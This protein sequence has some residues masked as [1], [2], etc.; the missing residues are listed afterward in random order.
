MH[1]RIQTSPQAEPIEIEHIKVDAFRY[2]D[3]RTT[4]RKE[5]IKLSSRNYISLFA[6]VL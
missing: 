2:L 1:I 4:N 3:L 6:D 5:V